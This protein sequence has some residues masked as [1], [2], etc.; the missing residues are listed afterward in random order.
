[1][2][3]A[4]TGWTQQFPG[5]PSGIPLDGGPPAVRSRAGKVFASL[6]AVTA[7]AAVAGVGTFGTFT[8]STTPIDTGVDDGLVSI[9]LSG[10]TGWARCRSSSRAC[11]TPIPRAACR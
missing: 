5:R 8:D 3:A 7:G 11:W 4:V 1:M 6:G 10:P 2:L 9:D